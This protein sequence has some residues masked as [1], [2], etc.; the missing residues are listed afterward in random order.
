MLY[1][2]G[3]GDGYHYFSSNLAEHN[4]AV[5]KYQRNQRKNNYRSTPTTQKESK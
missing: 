5:Q 3:K 2:V 4:L 1:F